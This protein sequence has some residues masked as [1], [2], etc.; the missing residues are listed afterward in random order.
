MEPNTTYAATL[1]DMI[2]E[3]RNKAYGAYVLRKLYHHHLNQAA[4]YAIALFIIGFS[5]PTL[6]NRFL[7]ETGIPAIKPKKEEGRW[8][9]ID[10]PKVDEIKAEKGVE[11]A[12]PKASG[13][14]VKNVTPKVVEETKPVTDEIPTQEQLKTA[15]SG[16][17]ASEGNGEENLNNPEPGGG[18]GTGSGAGTGEAPVSATTEPFLSVENM[19][20]FE[21]GLSK[22]MEFVGK[23]IKYPRAA[24]ANG[25]E[26]TV[27]VSF[28]VAAT[29]DLTEIQVLKGLGYGTEEEAM[30]VLKKVP[31][32]KPGSQNGRNVPVRMTLPIRLE[33][34]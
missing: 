24:Q 29:G 22:L 16:L 18:S 15:N 17:V 23:N 8:V 30:R 5:L 10:F 4:L 11:P 27:I 31:R 21:G 13:P 7:E 9:N 32:W 1:D 14:T 19:P 6:A 33:L 34:K 26:G 20:Q 2:F 12:A 3:G 25:I 28:V